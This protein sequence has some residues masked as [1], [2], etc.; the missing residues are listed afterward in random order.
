MAGPP[1]Q[2]ERVIVVYDCMLFLR[3]ASRPDRVSRLFQLVESGEATL[4]LSPEILAEIQ[5]VL[6]RPEHQARFPALTPAAVNRFLE[7][8]LRIGRFVGTVPDRYQ[9]VRDPKDSKYVNLALEAKAH[10]LVSWYKD[11]LELNDEASPVGQD[12]RARYPNLRV[13]TADAFLEA[14]RSERPAK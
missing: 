8:L 11:L 2:E 10:W 1:S 12:F 13:A 14:M 7:E 9:L 3:A 6:T 4:A 5:D